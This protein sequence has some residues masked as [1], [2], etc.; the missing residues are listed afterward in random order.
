[1]L[2]QVKK[3]VLVTEDE[4]SIRFSMA[5]ALE[6]ARLTL[7]VAEDG[8]QA[9][10]MLDLNAYGS[11]VLDLRIPKVDGY[12]VVAHIKEHHPGTPVII[13]TGLRPDELS[14][15]DT[16]VVKNIL[17]KPLDMEKLVMQITALSRPG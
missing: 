17:F 8:A 12:G 10:Q 11:V 4:P 5:L 7:D 15:I 13:V 14:G 1:V 6:R 3:D 2:R 16:S 9:I